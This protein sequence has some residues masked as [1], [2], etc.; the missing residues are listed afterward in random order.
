M[1]IACSH[2]SFDGNPLI[3]MIINKKEQIFR[4]N[5]TNVNMSKAFSRRT[6]FFNT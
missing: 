2:S 6:P 5:S 1:H 4:F 3:V